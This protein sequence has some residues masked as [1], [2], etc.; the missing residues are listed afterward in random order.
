MSDEYKF[1][2][3]TDPSV[4]VMTKNGENISKWSTSVKIEQP[5]PRTP[6]TL[7][8]T[9]VMVEPVEITLLDPEVKIKCVCP[10]CNYEGEDHEWNGSP[11]AIKKAIA[12][13]ILEEPGQFVKLI[14]ADKALGGDL[15][16]IIQQLYVGPEENG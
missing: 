14:A 11:S 2:L 6:P 1:I 7:E 13:W 15:S 5:S 9:Y 10:V 4:E 16:K 8:L 12:K 3:S